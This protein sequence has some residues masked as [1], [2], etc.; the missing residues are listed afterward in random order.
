MRL[1]APAFLPNHRSTAGL[2]EKPIT[3]LGTSMGSSLRDPPLHLA[4]RWLRET[5]SGC[6]TQLASPCLP[7]LPAARMKGS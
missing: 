6:G 2:R 7:N 5:K 3:L 1:Q 4:E